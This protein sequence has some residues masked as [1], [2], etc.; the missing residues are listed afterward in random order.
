MRHEYIS[1]TFSTCVPFRPHDGKRGGLEAAEAEANPALLQIIA[2]HKATIK[3]NGK[4]YSTAVYTIHSFRKVQEYMERMVA[5][6]FEELGKVVKLC[7][8]GLFYNPYP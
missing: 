6:A 4:T 8:V 5:V 3:Q 2:H 7:Q 1:E